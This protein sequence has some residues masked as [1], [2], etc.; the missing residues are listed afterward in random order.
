MKAL[1]NKDKQ[2]DII[3]AQERLKYLASDPLYAQEQALKKRWAQSFN[4]FA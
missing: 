4:I 3:L 1:A 2:Y